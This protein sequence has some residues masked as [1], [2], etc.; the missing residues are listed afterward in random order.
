[1]SI[2][3]MVLILR[4]L[5]ILF[6]LIFAGCN[7]LFSASLEEGRDLFRQRKLDDAIKTLQDAKGSLPPQEKKEASLL[8]AKCY[9]TKACHYTDDSD[10]RFEL[11]GKGLEEIETAQE[12]FGEEASLCYW[13]AILTGERANVRFT[14]ESF[15]AAEVIDDL[16]HRVIELDPSYENG[17]AYLALGRMY[18]KLPK[19]FGGGLEKSVQYLL[20]A[21]AYMEMLPPS[22]RTHTV[23]LFLAESY[24]ALGKYEK[25][26]VELKNGLRCRKNPDA[27]LEDEK[28]YNE[29]KRLLHGLNARDK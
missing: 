9:W 1:M 18:Y 12:E 4:K 20:S 29:M 19:L 24:I 8:L 15:G 22:E 14:L 3:V 2:P 6:F 17:G 21:K 26:R 5:C 25:A 7:S 13:K 10:T 23:Y 28:N 27:P 11:F 16:C